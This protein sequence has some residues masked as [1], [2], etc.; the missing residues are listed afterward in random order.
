MIIGHYKG[1]FPGECQFDRS[2]VCI[3]CEEKD[4]GMTKNR[5]AIS[6]Q[7]KDQWYLLTPEEKTLVKQG[8]LKDRSWIPPEVLTIPCLDW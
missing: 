3:H 5:K 1:C 4:P 2:D 8:K 7:V 6:Q